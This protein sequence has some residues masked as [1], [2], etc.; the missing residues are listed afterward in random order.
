MKYKSISLNALLNAIKTLLQ[1][2]FPL[3]TFPYA[4]R[5]IGVAG[6]GKYN[7]SSSIV[8]YFI[9]LSFNYSFI[10]RMIC[11]LI[12]FIYLINNIYNKKIKR[13]EKN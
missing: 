12:L 9:L 5:V 8:N 3:I 11:E 10:I 6:I 4:A 2:I 7:F 1:V 13:F